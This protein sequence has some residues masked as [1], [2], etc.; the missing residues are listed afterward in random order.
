MGRMLNYRDLHE[1]YQADPDHCLKQIGTLIEGRRINVNEFS[2][3]ELANATLGK[4]LVEAMEPGR[5]SGGIRLREAAS[6]V[7]TSAF[8]NITG[9]IVYST[10]KERFKTGTIYSDMLTT[11]KQTS[12]L[13]GEKIPGIG[14]I[15]DESEL[16]LEGQPYPTAG[17]NEEYV[18]TPQLEK[19]GKII[20]VTREI[21]VADRTGILLEVCGETAKYLAV[22]KQKRVMDAVFGVTNTYN[23]NGTSTNTYLASGAY[24][25]TVASNALVDWTDV[26]NALLAFDALTDPNTG[27]PI[28]EDILSGDLQVVVPTALGMT[29]R[30]ILSATEIR[31]GDGASSTTAAYSANPAEKTVYGRSLTYQLIS[32]PYVKSRTGSASTWFIGD[33][34]RAFNYMYAW[35]IE[36]AQAPTGSMEEFTRDIQMQ[37][38]VS[39]MGVTAV[40]EPRRVVKCTA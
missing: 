16:V 33:F 19:R 26:E 15:G 32:S 28:G 2:I 39:E 38:K 9:Q 1:Q 17:V 40:A 35:D 30:R 12:F 22:N 37:F 34:K 36:T 24:I 14:G 7:D 25:N 31:F 8:S 4:S 20:P 27:E 6:A 3:R 18:Q 5:K 13:K 11:P 10:V 29:A 23:R 21:I